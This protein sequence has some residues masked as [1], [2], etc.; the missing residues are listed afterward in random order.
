MNNVSNL[1]DQKGLEQV[2][3]LLHAKISLLTG[4]DINDLPTFPQFILANSWQEAKEK[5]L[6]DPINIYF[7]PLDSDCEDV[8]DDS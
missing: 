3:N 7:V 8:Y 2:L 4:V 1:L 5:S 6:S